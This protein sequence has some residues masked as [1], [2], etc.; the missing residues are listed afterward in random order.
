MNI[1]IIIL[2][3]KILLVTTILSVGL[4]TLEIYSPMSAKDDINRNITYTV[5][6]FGHI[7]FGKTLVGPLYV[8]Y[9]LDAC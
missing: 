8:A 4:A 2:M 1:A 3:L 7:P 9:P 5:A 6:N